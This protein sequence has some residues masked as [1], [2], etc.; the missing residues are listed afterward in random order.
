MVV[1]LTRCH[2]EVLG[3]LKGLWFLS[4]AVHFSMSAEACMGLE[5]MKYQ[6]LETLKSRL[7]STSMRLDTSSPVR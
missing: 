3:A 6:P 7:T 4:G 5:S 2:K 1:R